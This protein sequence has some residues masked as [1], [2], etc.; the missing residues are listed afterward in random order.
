MG[1]TPPVPQ[2]YTD[3]EIRVAVLISLGI[4]LCLIFMAP[5]RRRSASRLPRFLVW[6]FYLLAD[7]IADLALGLLL[8]NM[9]NI[10]SSNGNASLSVSTI[11]S[12]ASGGKHPAPAS[13][14]SSS[15]IIFAFWAPFLLLHLG[16]PD[17]ITAYSIEDAELWLRHF[18]GLLF[19]LFAASVVF[20][21]SLSGNHLIPASMLMFV[22]GILKYGERTYSLYCGSV[23]GFRES[24]LGEPVPGPN[25]AKLMEEYDAKL[26]AKL[27]AEIEIPIDKGEKRLEPIK[28]GSLQYIAYQFYQ[29][30]RRLF[31]DLILSFDERAISQ[32]YFLS[33][34]TDSNKAF[35]VVEMELNYIYDVTYTKAAVIHTHKGYVSRF[36]G[37]AC[38]ITAFLFFVALNKKGFL[39]VDIVITYTLLIG[40][41]VLDGAALLM[42]LL[43]DWT[44]VYLEESQMCRYNSTCWKWWAKKRDQMNHLIRNRRWG[45][46]MSQLNLI[47]YCLDNPVKPDRRIIHRIFYHVFKIKPLFHFCK[48]IA[49]KICCAEMFDQTIYVTHKEVNGEIKDFIFKRLISAESKKLKTTE[50]IK[51]VCQSRGQRALEKINN[52]KELQFNEVKD[53]NDWNQDKQKLKKKVKDMNQEKKDMNQEKRKRLQESIDPNTHDFDHSLLLW[54][55]ATELCYAESPTTDNSTEESLKEH[56]KRMG[57]LL[58]DYMLYL[59]VMQPAML[60]TTAGIGLIRFRD[61]CAEARRFFEQYGLNLKKE[62]AIKLLMNVNTS[63]DPVDVKGDRSKS[64]LFD[65]CILAECLQREKED[66]RWWLIAEVWADMLFYAASHCRGYGHVRQLSKG[67]EMLTIVWLLMAHMGV[68][69]MY[70]IKGGHAKAKLIA[71]K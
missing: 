42:L 24:V 60:A 58:S 54:H 19:E 61:T 22:V 66:T 31:V 21:C 44:N 4:Q 70:Q 14:S 55:I 38:I 23:D 57:K 25:Y 50:E 33:E 32:E 59:L 7:W 43:S 20:F 18:I 2:K 16:G 11:G 71:E 40:A 34:N 1:F 15:P 35:T 68:G 39:K 46:K 63:A 69:E 56:W 51:E 5:L 9:G 17:T 27:P 65:A 62:D 67:G 10:G 8:N 30:F 36:I 52:A 53:W 28:E 3:W 45:E 49:K 48:M 64:V 47:S 29:N 12:R 41:I 6:S 37:S 26:K 13:D